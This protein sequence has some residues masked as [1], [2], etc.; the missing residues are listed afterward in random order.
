MCSS[1]NARDPSRAVL[2]AVDGRGP[3]RYFAVAIVWPCELSVGAYVAAGRDVEVPRPSCSTCASQMQFWSWYRRYVRVDAKALKVSIRRARCSVCQ[4]TH[5]LLPSF[6]LA[7][8]LDVAETIG[9]AISKVVS[10][11]GGA[12]R[13]AVSAGVPHETA[14]GWLRAF[15]RRADEHAVSFSALVVELGG[16]AL[17]KSL[18][19]D[20]DALSAIGAAF[21]KAVEL[22]GWE[23][24]GCWGF[25]SSVS[26]GS[27]LAPNRDSPYLVIGRRRFMAPVP[28]QVRGNGD[29]HGP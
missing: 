11:K 5:A 21:V 8:R 19:A 17:T 15:G 29:S 14:R 9:A 1:L 12:R 25:C 4:V 2:V 26:G 10:G 3:G 27:V 20:R 6:L 28:S 18:D 7:R 24:I 22:P 16:K 23:A 13:A